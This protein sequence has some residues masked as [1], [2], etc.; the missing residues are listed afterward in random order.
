MIAVDSGAGEHFIKPGHAKLLSGLQQS[1]VSAIGVSGAPIKASNTGR[2]LVK[3]LDRKSGLIFTMDLGRGHT[4]PDL[5]VSLLS[6]SKLIP[7]GSSFYFSKE[8]RD[9]AA[10][11]RSQNYAGTEKWIVFPTGV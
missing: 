7:T 5:P 6:V 9:E 10:E 2:L 8:E 11:R 3:L 4:L 1:R